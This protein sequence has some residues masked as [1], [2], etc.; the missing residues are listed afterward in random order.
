ML[1]PQ[2]RQLQQLITPNAGAIAQGLNQGMSLANQ[3]QQ[4]QLGQQTQQ[5]NQMQL[6]QAQQAMT[7]EQAQEALGSIAK[8]AETVMSLPTD[9]QRYNFLANR[10]DQLA[11]QGRNTEQTDDALRIGMNEGFTSPAFDQAMQEGLQTANSMGVY[12][13]Q[14]Q[15]QRAAQT[16]AQA[17]NT[18]STKDK[19]AQR[20]KFRSEINTLGGKNLLDMK[21]QMGKITGAKISGVGDVTM[22]KTI[23]KMI[24]QGIVTS[25][26]FDQIANSSGLADSFKGMMSKI[27]GG[28]QLAPEVRQ[29]IKDQAQALYDANLRQVKSVADGIESDA[30]S[31]GV[32]NVIPSAYKKLFEGVTNITEGEPV[33]EVDTTGWTPMQDANGNRALVGPNGEIKEL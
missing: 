17:E 1:I 28:G 16:K 22:L 6:D 21:A 33:Q 24:D 2:P 25:D 19:N 11:A 14:Q 10:R 26:D 9:D 30:E 4:N 7:K 20:Q 29:Q 8:G 27:V 23:N 31:Y 3:Y 12:T 13:E 32:S 15:M 18:L 5:L